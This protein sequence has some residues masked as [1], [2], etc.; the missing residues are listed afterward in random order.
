MSAGIA[1]NKLLSKIGSG[2]HKPGQQTLI[3]SERY[4]VG[5]VVFVWHSVCV[6]GV[7]FGFLLS[8]LV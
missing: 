2:F 7:V 6:C 3:P 8:S 5:D 4:A 1:H